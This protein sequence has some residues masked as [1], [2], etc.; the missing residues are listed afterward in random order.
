MPFL[1]KDLVFRILR[2][3]VWPALPKDLVLAPKKVA[4]TPKDLALMPTNLVITPKDLALSFIT[5]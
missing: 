5:N 3:P 2:V 1:P 4:L